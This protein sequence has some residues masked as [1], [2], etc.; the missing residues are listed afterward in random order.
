M[1][2]SRL[3]S[4]LINPLFAQAC[5]V[6]CS[7]VVLCNTSLLPC[8]LVERALTA[9]VQRTLIATRHKGAIE[10]AK[11][12][13]SNMTTAMLESRRQDYVDTLKTMV[14]FPLAVYIY[15]SIYLEL[16]IL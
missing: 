4:Q 2:I 16:C 10:A 15:I 1:H 13:L 3:K 8:P 6:V 9:V 5:C 12:C 7:R 14:I 11:L